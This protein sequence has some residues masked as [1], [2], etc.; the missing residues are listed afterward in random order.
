MI[1]A[2]L[3]GVVVAIFLP[4]GLYLDEVTCLQL[5]P[6]FESPQTVSKESKELLTQA[7]ALY[8]QSKQGPAEHF[9][10][11]KPVTVFGINGKVAKLSV[12]RAMFG[13]DLQ[14]AQ[15]WQRVYAAHHNGATP[16]V[17]L[18]LKWVTGL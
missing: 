7:T 15:L 13:L 14:Y 5:L 17:H 2:A 3:L 6:S 4:L 18:T 12:D 1:V 11:A 16:C 9:P 10:L 8:Y